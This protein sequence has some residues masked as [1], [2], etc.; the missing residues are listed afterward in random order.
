MQHCA[1]CVCNLKEGHLG[2]KIYLI[3][4]NPENRDADRVFINVCLEQNFIGLSTLLYNP[5]TTWL[6][7]FQNATGLQREILSHQ[8]IIIKNRYRN[9]MKCHQRLGHQFDPTTLHSDKLSWWQT[10]AWNIPKRRKHQRKPCGS[11]ESTERRESSYEPPDIV[12][13]VQPWKMHGF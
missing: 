7:N 5:K 8:C 13:L 2:S 6:D 3:D 1:N 12:H 4:C 11:K 9:A 10:F